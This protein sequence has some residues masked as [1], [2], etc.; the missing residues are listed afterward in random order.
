MANRIE[1]SCS[2]ADSS[3]RVGDC[4]IWAEIQYLDSG[5]D[6][7]EYLLNGSPTGPQ[8]PT[9]D[10]ITLDSSS[11]SWSASLALLLVFLAGVIGVGVDIYLAVSGS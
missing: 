10:F 7:R 9:D 2:R 3:F 5:T 6:Y 1:R 11:V 8:A 4:Y